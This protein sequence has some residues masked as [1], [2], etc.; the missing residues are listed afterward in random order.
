MTPSPVTVPASMTVREFLDGYLFRARHQSLPVT[1]DGDRATGL[2]TFNRIQQVP[3]GQRDHTRLADTACP[4]ADV[5]TAAPDDS[6][7]DLLRA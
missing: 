6:A 5:P 2:V 4:L 1:Q 7:A 3:P